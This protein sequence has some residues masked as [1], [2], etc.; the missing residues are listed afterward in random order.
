MP[1]P[2]FAGGLWQIGVVGHSEIG[3]TT[4]LGF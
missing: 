4:T 2:P 3:Q 1:V